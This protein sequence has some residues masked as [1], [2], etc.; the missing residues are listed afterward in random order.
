LLDN[1]TPSVVWSIQDR[2]V[3][4]WNGRVDA[5]I[6]FPL[7]CWLVIQVDGPTHKHKAIAGCSVHQQQL[8]DERLNQ[9]VVPQGTSVLRLDNEHD[10]RAWGQALDAAV[11]A[12]MLPNAVPQIFWG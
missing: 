12:C 9:Q 10:D 3:R 8:R 4:K 1:M 7:R 6:Y 5:C 11:A 2:A